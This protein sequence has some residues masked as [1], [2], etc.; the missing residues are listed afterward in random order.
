MYR[1]LVILFS[2]LVGA[3]C[4]Q[5]NE[6]ICGS[7]PLLPDNGRIV[8][9]A[10]AIP[11]DWPWQVSLNNNGRH[12]CGG[13][14]INN[15]WVVSAAHCF[16]GSTAGYTILLGV[17]DRILQ[18]AWVVIRRFKNLINHPN[19]NAA[20]LRGDI[21]LIKMDSAVNYTEYI[22]PICMP[23]QTEHNDFHA[24]DRIHV[25]GWGSAQI[26]GALFIK[27]MQGSHIVLTEAR[28][29]TK[30]GARFDAATQIAAGDN[31]D[32]AGPCQ[33]D[34]GGPFTKMNDDGKWTSIGVVSWGIGCGNGGVYSRTDRYLPWLSS[35]M[36]AYPN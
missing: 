30:Y 20:T 15:E 3:N 6:A 16:S 13:S 36:A 18:E 23:N 32:V 34:S 27:K 17:H 19:W 5:W 24:G 2:L 31:G 11:G 33:G 12:F 10:E 21:S 22:R 7:R 26:G 25:T 35:T 8:G 14:L 28:A 9:G 29:R 1:G 4:Q